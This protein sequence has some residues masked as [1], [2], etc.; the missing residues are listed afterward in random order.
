MFENFH[1][2][3]SSYDPEKVEWRNYKDLNNK[4]NKIDLDYCL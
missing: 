2:V 3:F 1:I 4:D